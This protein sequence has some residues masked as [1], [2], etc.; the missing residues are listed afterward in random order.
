MRFSVMGALRRFT[1]SLRELGLRTTIFRFYVVIVD[2]FFDR[3]YGTD[4]FTWSGQDDVTIEN[5]N[6]ERGQSYQGTRI[7]PLRKLLNSIK[8]MIPANGVLVDIGCG[9]GR[10]LLIASQFGFRKARGVEYAHELCEIAKNNC[11]VFK[12]KTG[13]E[14]E[15]QI[16]EADAANYVI[17]NDENVFFMFNPFDKVVMNEV[18]NNISASLK[19]QPRRILIIYCTPTCGSFIEQQGSFVK[20]GEFIFAGLEFA[21]YSDSESFSKSDNALQPTQ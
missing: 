18:L 4:T 13:S 7:V 17:K 20:S 1:K 12:R 19:I 10:V 2:F 8:S 6:K 16:I 14:T 11:A 15:F 9:K 3:K 5:D 21:I